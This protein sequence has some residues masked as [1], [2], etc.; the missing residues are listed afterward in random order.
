VSIGV[1]AVS[2]AAVV[3]AAVFAAPVASGGVVDRDGR[4][5]TCAI[6]DMPAGQRGYDDWASTLLDTERTLDE[7]YVPPDLVRVNG[8]RLAH[9][10]PVRVRAFVAPRLAALARAAEQAGTSI[11][12]TSGYRSFPDQM[13]TFAS[14]ERA[15][16]RDFAVASAARPGH[17]E[18][19]LGTAVD[20][21]GDMAWLAANAWRF[22]FVMSYPPAQSPARTCYKPEAWHYRYFGI[23]RAAAI[24]RSG[25]SPRE[26]LWINGSG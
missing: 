13:A 25:L 26:W 4:L 8:I 3:A 15:Y 16:G 23:D 19:Q 22:G 20:L 5:P 6:G 14:L 7:G 1:A 9:G 18:H 24:H 21:G 10:R 2:A 12:V 17:S 11:A